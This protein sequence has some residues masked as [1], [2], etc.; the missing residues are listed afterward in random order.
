MNLL[1]TSFEKTD[2]KKL[3][4]TQVFGQILA[5]TKYFQKLL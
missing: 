4:S 3:L 1:E 5:D 2:A